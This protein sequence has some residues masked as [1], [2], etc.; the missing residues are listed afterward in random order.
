MGGE[1][2]KNKGGLCKGRFARTPGGVHLSLEGFGGEKKKGNCT[3][4]RGRKGKFFRN[5]SKKKKNRSGMQ[6]PER[7]TENS[8]DHVVPM[9]SA[10]KGKAGELKGLEPLLGGH[11]GGRRVQQKKAKL[12]RDTNAWKRRQQKQTLLGEPDAPDQR[13][14]TARKRKSGAKKVWGTVPLGTAETRPHRA[15]KRRT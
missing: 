7:R 10:E 5:A 3:T 12:W 8:K 15:K 14:S 11:R 1:H 6:Q 4:V 2:I 9:G 13:Q